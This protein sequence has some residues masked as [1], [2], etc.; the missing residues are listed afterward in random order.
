LQRKYRKVL[1]A[2][3]P[4]GAIGASLLLGSLAPALARPHPDRLQPVSSGEMRVADRLAAI[5]HAVSDI[6]GRG[7]AEGG[8]Q[9]AWWGNWRNGGG[10]AGAWRN[11]G[12]R[13][14]GWRNGGWRNGGWP[15]FWRNW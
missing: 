9:L 2:V 1:A 14:G 15:N 3:V 7:T 6:A 12:W 8:G 10:S 5:R 11:G 13:N 4:L